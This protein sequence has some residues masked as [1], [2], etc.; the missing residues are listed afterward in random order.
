[1]RLF[2]WGATRSGRVYA[3]VSRA[4]CFSLCVSAGIVQRAEAQTTVVLNVPGS[5]VSDTTTRTR[6]APCS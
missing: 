4:L 1:M 5:Q 2:N 6:T 3:H